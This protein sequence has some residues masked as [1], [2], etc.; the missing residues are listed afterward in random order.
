M[1]KRVLIC[2]AVVAAGALAIAVHRFNLSGGGAPL[3]GQTRADFMRSVVEGCATRQKA[4]PGNENLDPAVIERFCGCY[5]D[6]LVKHVSTAD[7]E[8]LTGRA[9]A[10]I[11][12][13]MRPRMAEADRACLKALDER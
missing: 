13:E 2:L 6:E 10:E 9:A 3:S 1:I 8:R 7:L 4:S 11:Q 5:A 12:S